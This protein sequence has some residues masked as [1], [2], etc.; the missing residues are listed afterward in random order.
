MIKIKHP[1]KKWKFDVQ[2]V[3]LGIG[4]REPG[5]PDPNNFTFGEFTD[6]VG[7]LIDL[8]I[9]TNV[10][11]KWNLRTHI[12]YI[13]NVIKPEDYFDRVLHWSEVD[14]IYHDVN[15]EELSFATDDY[16]AWC[17][18]GIIPESHIYINL[19][20]SRSFTLSKFTI[21]PFYSVWLTNERARIITNGY[22]EISSG[23]IINETLLTYIDFGLSPIPYVGL[24]VEFDK[25][26]VG[27]G[28]GDG[29][30]PT[31]STYVRLGYKL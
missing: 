30:S 10:Y 19:G 29:T 31:P 27:F 12:A 23:K 22:Q 8:G 1:Q 24:D 6:H 14:E 21:T 11:G 9:S 15:G 18:N 3:S 26:L 17:V 16:R 13:G 7:Q 20:I 25:F 5:V 28:L 4:L 2:N